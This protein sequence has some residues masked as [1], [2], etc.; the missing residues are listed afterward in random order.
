MGLILEA[1]PCNIFFS[2]GECLE[3]ALGI[4]IVDHYL[5]IL[6]HLFRRVMLEI[7][8]HVGFCYLVAVAS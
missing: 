8:I 4:G 2:G 3:R 1:A 7:H 5:K 6:L